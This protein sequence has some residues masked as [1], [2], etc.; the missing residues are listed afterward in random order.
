VSKLISE[1]FKVD[2]DKEGCKVNDVQG[3]V[4]VEA[5]R[6]KNLHLLNVK[7]HKDTAHIA[8]SLDEGAMLWHERVDMQRLLRLDGIEAVGSEILRRTQV[9]CHVFTTT[10]FLML[11]SKLLK[12]NWKPSS[13]SIPC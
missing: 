10:T 2:F 3:V 9:S 13:T 1:G 7:V 4:M 12:K 8:N 5:Q 11:G 6:D